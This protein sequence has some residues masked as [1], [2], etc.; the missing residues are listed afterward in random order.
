MI[1][2]GG[3]QPLFA[4]NLHGVR[5]PSKTASLAAAV[6]VVEPTQA[7]QVAGSLHSDVACTGAGLG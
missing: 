7:F 2:F 5:A 4:G 1:E 6:V 3:R